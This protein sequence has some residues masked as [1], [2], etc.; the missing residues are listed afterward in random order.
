MY[1]NSYYIIEKKNPPNPVLT[2]CSLSC[3]EK[4][5]YIYFEPQACG[6]RRGVRC[7][8]VVTLPLRASVTIGSHHLSS[9]DEI[10][11]YS[12]TCR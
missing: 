3:T 12:C 11:L 10:N 5:I 4:Y 7:V 2:S 1:T 9:I 6:Y 8:E